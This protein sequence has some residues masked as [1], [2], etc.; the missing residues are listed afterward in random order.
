MLKKFFSP[1]N[2]SFIT[3]VAMLLFRVWI[4]LT[5]F[6]NHGLAKLKGFNTL[7]SD[8]ADPFGIGSTPSL[9]LA[10]FAEA[11]ASILLVLGLLTRFGA[12][13]LAITMG[14]A[15]VV[16]HKGVLSGP[17]NGELAFIYFAC[18]LIL[19]MVGP[20][21]FSFDYYLFRGEAKRQD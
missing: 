13:T 21:R 16:V 6:L 14:V 17:R 11:F 15:F 4:G 18:Y 2:R 9:I 7:A 19:F 3:S 20:G 8:F 12:L 5:M 1:G 10:I